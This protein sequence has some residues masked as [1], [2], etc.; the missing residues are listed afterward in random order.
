MPVGMPPLTAPI[1]T[2]RPATFSPGPRPTALSTSP[3]PAA[4][5]WRRF[6]LYPGV[7]PYLF[8]APALLPGAVFYLL[9]V[10][11]S[12]G[13]SFTDWTMLSPPRWVGFGNYTYLLT[14]DP[15]F[16]GTVLHTLVLAL[17]ATVTGVP[18]ALLIAWGIGTGR[19]KSA[20]R[21][22]YWLPMV[23]NV[24]AVAYA[25]RFVLDPADGLANR[26]L[27]HLGLGGPEWLASPD[28]AMA[29][30][31][32]IIVWAGL[33][34]NVLLFSAGLEDVDETLYEAARLDGA[35]SWRVLIHVTLPMLRPAT[36][37][38]SVTT[39]IGGLGSFALVLV[40]TGGGPEGSTNVTALYMY[41][42]AFEHL[43]LGRASAAAVLL[44]AIIMLLTLLQLKLFRQGG[45]DAH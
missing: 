32:A 1:D 38:A 9:P 18:L 11:V 27:G 36:L 37:F 20:W 42:M 16:W 10:V 3:R 31:I 13:L 39:L 5:V 29:S 2:Q 30:V 24:V 41:Q 23:T 44:F 43:R 25:W 45:V 8:L 14:I 7:T 40:M 21:A 6:R 35:G 15:Q 22:L 12:A 34:Q 17:G 26:L 19:G 33:G 4:R 28:T